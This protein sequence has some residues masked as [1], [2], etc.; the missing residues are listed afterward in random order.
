MEKNII[1]WNE[2]LYSEL[3]RKESRELEDILTSDELKEFLEILDNDILVVL[4]GDGTLLEAVQENYLRKRAFLG[5][6]FWNKGFLLND[7]S[8]I[9]KKP[10]LEKR[11]YN[12]LEMCIGN[13]S[14]AIAMNEFDIKAW[15]GK[16]LD[17]DISVND[18]H[19][20]SLIWDGIIVSSPAGSTGYSSSLG[21]AILPHGLWAYIMTPKA[22]WKPKWLAPIILSDSQEL[23]I[24]TQGRK[25]PV[26]FYA[27]GRLIDRYDHENVSL[28][29]KKSDISI[30]LLI[31]CER[32]CSWDYK[33]LEEQ[34]FVQK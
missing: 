9:W 5:I 32:Q 31:A 17:L 30:E 1:S 27:D 21:W 7:M 3:K 18:S 14:C 20:L 23:L 12:L 4:G 11:L 22:P 15:D 25:N 29:L 28:T 24:R 10:K 19:H 16:M 6:N 34:G 2:V 26:E 8:I 13:T 33:V